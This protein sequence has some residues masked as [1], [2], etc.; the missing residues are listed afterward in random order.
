MG[1]LGNIVMRASSK[2]INP[3]CKIPTSLNESPLSQEES[4]I[5]EKCKMIAAVVE[6][7]VEQGRISDGLIVVADLISDLNKYWT[8]HQPWNLVKDKSELGQ[9]RLS[10]VMHI[11]FESIRIAALLLQ[12]VMP[13]KMK[14]LLDQLQVPQS[15]RYFQNAQIGGCTLTNRSMEPGFALFKKIEGPQ[16]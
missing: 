13:E 7:H 6:K 5:L 3:T 14:L 11:T 15:E 9:A 10:N 8:V 4:D 1:Q 2:K 16:V 12:P